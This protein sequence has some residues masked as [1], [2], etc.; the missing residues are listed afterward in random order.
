M[1][2]GDVPSVTQESRA[3]L[4]E[5]YNKNPLQVM[6]PVKEF[7]S[8]SSGEEINVENINV[9]M[10]DADVDL[11]FDSEG[12]SLIYSGYPA[13]T[14]LGIPRDAST[15]TVAADCVAMYM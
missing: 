5:D 6:A 12:E 1:G 7:L 13:H 10:F 14:P 3:H 8:V 11:S 4:P 2:F 15:L 9:I